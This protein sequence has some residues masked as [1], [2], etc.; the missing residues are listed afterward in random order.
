MSLP[1]SIFGFRFIA[2]KLPR[3]VAVP[4]QPGYRYLYLDGNSNGFKVSRYSVEDTRS[5]MGATL[6]QVYMGARSQRD[7]L[8]YV[9]YND[10]NPDGKLKF[11]NRVA[12]LVLAYWLQMNFV[13]N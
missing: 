1:Y 12:M 10:A 3:T 4:V 9:F 5:A 6:Q 8:A 11:K 7:S 13:Y 2:Y